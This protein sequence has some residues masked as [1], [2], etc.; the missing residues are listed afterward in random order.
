MQARA[1]LEDGILAVVFAEVADGFVPVPEIQLADA[2]IQVHCL[3]CLA[4]VLVDDLCEPEDI[5]VTVE[6]QL[7]FPVAEIGLG[8]IYLSES[9]LSG[10][11]VAVFVVKEDADGGE[12]DYGNSRHDDFLVA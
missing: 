1:R 7:V 2:C 9:F 5:A 3:S 8:L 10:R 12:D 6:R 11:H 4:A